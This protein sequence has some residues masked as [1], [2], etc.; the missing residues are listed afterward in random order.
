MKGA[1]K[2]ALLFHFWNS[3]VPSTLM[4]ITISSGLPEASRGTEST[5][6]LNA[7]PCCHV[8]QSMTAGV[9]GVGGGVDSGFGGT[10]ICCGW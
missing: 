3:P 5:K 7:L 4:S 8:S 2:N 1:P 10:A 6:P 9:G